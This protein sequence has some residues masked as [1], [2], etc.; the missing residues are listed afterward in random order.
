[1]CMG[2]K[3]S[4]LS[5]LR[6]CLCLFLVRLECGLV[7]LAQSCLQLGGVNLAAVVEVDGF[8]ELVDV[9]CVDLPG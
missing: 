1:M 3:P 6:L 8:K 4:Q 2:D 7:K 9:L 5:G